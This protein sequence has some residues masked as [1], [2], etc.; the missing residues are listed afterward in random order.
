VTSSAGRRPPGMLESEVMAVLW[1]ADGALSA[2]EVQATIGGKLA[3]NTVQT[4]LIRLY[5]KKLLQRRRAGRG[6]LYWPVEDA[7]TATA[8]RMR[9]A[10]AGRA[11]RHA[12]L[13]RFAA[14]LDD[15][16]ADLLR[17]VLA[18]TRRQPS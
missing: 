13:Q 12:V 15:A 8:T 9:A 11:D 4:I 7:A 18:E 6:H 3:Y 17:Q 2:A 16:D 1:A 5:E 10:L 14:T